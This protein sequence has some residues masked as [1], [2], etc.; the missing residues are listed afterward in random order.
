[1]L[2]LN[3]PVVT[4][5][6]GGKGT[7]ASS[8]KDKRPSNADPLD[9]DSGQ[10]A[11]E[12]HEHEGEGIGGVDEPGFLFTSSAERVHSAPDAWRAEVAES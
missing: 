12:N 1:M 4:V 5:E 11:G 3:S 7:V 10:G 6:S 2:D 9:E 8:T